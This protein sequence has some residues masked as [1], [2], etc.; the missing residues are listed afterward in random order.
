MEI[1]V[2][3]ANFAACLHS[4]ATL[5]PQQT[6]QTSRG[7][8]ALGGARG[9]GG[10][11]RVLGHVPGGDMHAGAVCLGI[12]ARTRVACECVVEVWMLTNKGPS[13]NSRTIVERRLHHVGDALGG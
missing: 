7:K 5:H 9:V 3:M 8:H 2:K 11:L 4:L 1:V 12:R 10:Q 13:I 6:Q